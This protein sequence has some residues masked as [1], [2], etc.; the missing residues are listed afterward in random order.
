[1]MLFPVSEFEQVPVSLTKEFC[2]VI[3]IYYNVMYIY[4]FIFIY[5]ECTY[6]CVYIL[7]N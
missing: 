4:I 6:I 7:G 1:M 2:D 5:L 3:T